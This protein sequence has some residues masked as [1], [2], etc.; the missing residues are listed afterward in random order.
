MKPETSQKVQNVFL[1]AI[2]GM[3]VPLAIG[4]GGGFWVTKGD[5]ERMANEGLLAARATICVAQFTDA[6][7]Y[8][9]RL[10][11]YKALD[12]SA[13]GVFVEK[14]GWAKMPGEGKA[15]DAVKQS[16]SNA[17]DALV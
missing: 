2:V 5:A 16:C 8:Q 17:L 6:P 9:G 4:F 1:A 7:N 10:K 12:Y 13:K 3:A 14:G 11:E 15:N